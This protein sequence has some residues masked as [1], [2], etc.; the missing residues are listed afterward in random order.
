MKTIKYL[1]VALVM[2]TSTSAVMAQKLGSVKN[3]ELIQ[4][5]VAKD[6]VQTKLDAHY[7]DLSEMADAMQVEFNG[8]LEEYQKNQASYSDVVKSQ[9]EKELQRLQQSIQEFIQTSETSIQAKQ[10]ELMTPIYEKLRE[11]A[12]KVGNSGGFAML[13]DADSQMYLNPS[14]VTDVTALMSKEM[15]L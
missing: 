10:Q 12:Q 1:V 9:K 4:K 7:K 15:G 6:S 5:M 8:K 3:S 11:A 2:M 13:F 14:Q